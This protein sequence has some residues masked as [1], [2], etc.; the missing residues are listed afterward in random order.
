VRKPQLLGTSCLFLSLGN[1][2]DL[3]QS[4]TQAP[5]AEQFIPKSCKQVAAAAAKKGI[6]A[7][8]TFYYLNAVIDYSLYSLHANLTVHPEYRLKNRTGG[9]Y[10]ALGKSW[11]FNHSN[12]DERDLWINDCMQAVH[13]GCTGGCFI[14]QSNN[15]PLDTK[16]ISPEN[17]AIFRAAHMATLVEL[18]G[19]IAAATNSKSVILHNNGVSGS[20]TKAIMVENFAASEKCILEVQK[21]AVLGI[22]VEAHAGDLADGTEPGPFSTCANGGTNSMAAFLI[23]AG[24]FMYYHCSGTAEGAATKWSVN[25]NW[26]TGF[27]YWLDW[28]PEYDK[29]LGAPTGAGVKHGNVWSRTFATGTEVQFDAV[30]RNGTIWWS[31][32][33]VQRGPVPAVPPS[34]YDTG[35]TWQ[36]FP[37]G[38]HSPL[39]E[40]N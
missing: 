37:P 17:E 19:R 22:T 18:D 2:T 31:D 12:S 16:Q 3:P 36:T 29:P 27:D 8:A 5:A 4:S 25:P 14:D 24:D 35:C 40:L 6:P 28:R 11:T 39:S 20:T 7:P 26:P 1:G 30:L 38:T 21:L 34:Q 33:T 15:E 9:D 13:D 32:G 23:A 10:H